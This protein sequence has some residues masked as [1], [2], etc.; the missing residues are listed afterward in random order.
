MSTPLNTSLFA[1]LKGEV[2]FNTRLSDGAY[3]FYSL[4]LYLSGKNTHCWHTQAVL[5]AHMGL[6]GKYPTRT[7]RNYQNECERAGIIRVERPGHHQAN[8]YYPLVRVIP[9]DRVVI[10]DESPTPKDR[11]GESAKDRKEES[12]KLHAP[13]Y[14][15]H[16]RASRPVNSWKR[17]KQEAGATEMFR[18]MGLKM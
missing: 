18:R 12:P 17:M 3:R 7:I 8:K 11:K 15:Q 2:I 14:I 13:N 16:E 4:I 1:Q 10:H 5:A 9:Q 6:K